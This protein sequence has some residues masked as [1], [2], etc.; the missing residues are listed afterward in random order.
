[1]G[2]G[3]PL[4]VKLHQ[5]IVSQFKDN[6]SQRKTAKNLGLSPSTVHN[7]VKRFRESGEILV[8]KGQG[9]DPLMNACMT[10]QLSG[11]IV[12]E[13]LPCSHAMMDLATP[14]MQ[15]LML[16]ILERQ[17]LPSRRRLF[18]GIHVY[19][20]KKIRH[21]ARVRHRSVCA[22]LACLQSRSVSY[23]NCMAHHEE[24]NQTKVTMDCWAVQALYCIH[25]E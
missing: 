3:S 5:R 14:L 11:G 17:M 7:I 23:W 21:F 8:H 18:P 25:Q 4:C 19:F 9:Q 16:G 6:V 22:W 24:E 13:M 10:I 15:R 2:H 1:M 20:S 12:W